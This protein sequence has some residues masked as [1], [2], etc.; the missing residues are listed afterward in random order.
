MVAAELKIAPR[1][2][3]EATAPKAA[4]PA[5]TVPAAKR[6][7]LPGGGS[8]TIPPANNPTLAVA[9]EVGKINSVHKL[10]EYLKPMIGR[11]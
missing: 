6:Q 8:R 5:Q 10:R 3:G 11:R 9:E 4:A 7:I 2:K 1:R